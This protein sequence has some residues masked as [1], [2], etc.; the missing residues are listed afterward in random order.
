MAK[1][2]ADDGS[3]CPT[4][5]NAFATNKGYNPIP[6]GV[7]EMA[8]APTTKQVNMVSSVIPLTPSNPCAQTQNIVMYA[9]Q[10]NKVCNK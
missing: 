9:N 5:I 10:I 7:K 8:T 4:S 3:C 2:D 1:P 6:P